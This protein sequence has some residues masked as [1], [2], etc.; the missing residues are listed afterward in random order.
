MSLW[1]P[2]PLRGR[3]LCLAG[4]FESDHEGH[5]SYHRI[6]IRHMNSP[7]SRSLSS[8]LASRL[9]LLSCRS[10]S[11][12]IRFCSLASS[13]R[14]HAMIQGSGILLVGRREWKGRRERESAARARQPTGRLFVVVGSTCIISPTWITGT[15]SLAS[16][17]P[18]CWQSSRRRWP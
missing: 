5:I 11:W 2:C 7:S 16:L 12:L 4:S 15:L 1:G 8:R 10:I 9:S 6:I 18:S 13:D 17:S 14:Q 3:D